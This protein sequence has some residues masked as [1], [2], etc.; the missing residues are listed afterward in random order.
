LHRQLDDVIR[1]AHQAGVTRMITI[2]TSVQDARD[3]IALCGSNASVRCAIGVHPNHCDDA[4]ISDIDALR[5]L[6]RDPSV[7][8][9]GEM[10]LDY[11]YDNDRARQRLFF[12]AQLSL[13]IE[14]SRPVVI[15]CRE[16]V[17]DA[18]AMMRGFPRERAVFHCFTGTPDEAQQ[19]LDAGF[20]LGFDGPVTFKKGDALR[21]AARLTPRDRLLLETDSPYLSPEPMRKQKTNEPALV[22]Y[23]ADMI[24]QLWGVTRE[25]VDRITTENAERL[26]AIPML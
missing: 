7:V 19:I 5:D 1:R 22:V 17:A 2:G 3:A 10:G 25:E 11:H 18:L 4:D 20:F 9:L 6:Q 15:H 24:A 21:D 13:A 23:V 16:A 12:E 8:A 26:F 14:V